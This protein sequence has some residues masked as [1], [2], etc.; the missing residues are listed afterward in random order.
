MEQ[1]IEK[2]VKNIERAHGTKIAILGFARE[3]RSL[4]AFLPNDPEFHGAEIWVL[5]S[6]EKID[7]PPGMRSRLGADYLSDLGDFD[8]IFRTPG[9][10]YN[11]PE[12][13]DAI[14]QG[15]NISSA[16]KLFF[17]RCPGKIVG[18]T[19]TKGKG[20]TSTLTYEILKAAGKKVFL[21]GNSLWIWKKARM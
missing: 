9:I 8:I 7:V 4:A 15:V 10:R 13:Q 17:E 18:I 14:K 11:L 19:G 1:K 16:T 3:G 20:T 5:D 6:D 2:A 12:I 21:A